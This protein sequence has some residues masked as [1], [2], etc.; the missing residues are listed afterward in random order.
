M[1][2]SLE[3][4]YLAMSMRPRG[5]SRCIPHLGTL[6]TKECSSLGQQV[7]MHTGSMISCTT[8]HR[9]VFGSVHCFAGTPVNAARQACCCLVASRID[10]DWACVVLQLD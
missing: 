3:Q 4:T 7:S 9:S 8:Q 10:I 6:Y 2:R 1:M 5:V